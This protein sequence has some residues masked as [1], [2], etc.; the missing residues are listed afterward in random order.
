MRIVIAIT[1][2][3]AAGLSVAPHVP[4]DEIRSAESIDDLR[5]LVE[6]ERGES[7]DT[8]VA[9][10]ARCGQLQSAWQRSTCED[11]LAARF[12]SGDSTPQSVLRLHCTRVGSVWDA[13]LPEPPAL[14]TD[15]F[16]GWL[17][18]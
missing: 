8:R 17:S 6:G 2:L 18:G 9:L 14:C 13:P 11:S 15:R 1:V 7:E 16:G 10:E 12:S 5:A 4:F 3:V